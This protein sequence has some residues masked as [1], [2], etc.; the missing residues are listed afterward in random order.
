MSIRTTRRLVRAYGP[1]WALAG[2]PELDLVTAPNGGSGTSSDAEFATECD[3]ANHPR[4]RQRRPAVIAAKAPR[5]AG[6]WRATELRR[7]A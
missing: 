4:L 3:G 2:V 7:A 1:I 5:R 6:Q